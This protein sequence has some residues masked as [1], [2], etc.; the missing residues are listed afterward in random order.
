MA[1]SNSKTTGAKPLGQINL[2][3]SLQVA[4]YG[5]NLSLLDAKE[6]KG[7]LHYV[8]HIGDLTDND[9]DGIFSSRKRTGMMS[10]VH[11]E[12]DGTTLHDKYYKLKSGLPGTAITDWEELL[13][14]GSTVIIN[15]IQTVTNIA[16]RNA[17][18]GISTGDV[19]HVTDASADIAIITGGASY[20]Y[21]GST[22]TRILG[23]DGI[24]PVDVVSNTAARHV[25]NEDSALDAS[26]LNVT[27]LDINAHINDAAK[28]AEINDSAGLTNTNDIWSADKIKTELNI[29]VADVTAN[30]VDIANLISAV[31][32]K[33]DVILGYSLVDDLEVVKIH[34]RNKD[35][36]FKT[37]DYPNLNG[38]G[39]VITDIAGLRQ[40]FS[41]N[42]DIGT[43][44]NYV[45]SS[46]NKEVKYVL[47]ANNVADNGTSIIRPADYAI[48]SNEKVW[49]IIGVGIHTINDIADVDTTGI[50]VGDAL[51]WNGTSFE[52]VGGL[53]TTNINSLI[54]VDTTTSLPNAGEV[55]TWNGSNWIPS[56]IA[57]AAG[58][59]S[60]NS[61]TGVVVLN[62]DNIAQGSTNI[63]YSD[64]L[65][66]ANSNVVANTAKISYTDSVAVGLNTAKVGISSQQTNDIVS[67]NAKVGYTDA[68]VS[69][70]TDV[71]ANTSKV[72]ITPSQASDITSNNSKVSYTDAS[73]VG[74]NTAKVGITT[75]QANEITANN[76]KVGITPTQASDIT[77]NNSKS[78]ITSGQSSDITANNAKISY[79]DAA[80]VANNTA[81]TGI[82]SG[83][84]SDITTN[85]AKIS[86]T[87]SAA[88]T[89]NTSK[90]GITPT[91]AS[92]I[93]T[94][95]SKISYTDA[96]AVGLNTA[97]VS[98]NGS[99]DS[100]SDVDTS[101]SAPSTGEFL[102]WD[103]SNWVPDAIPV[104]TTL[105]DVG[106][107]TVTS[108]TSGDIIQWNGS[109]WVNIA[110]PSSNPTSVIAS[111][112]LSTFIVS[113]HTTFDLSGANLAHKLIEVTMDEAFTGN[114]TFTNGIKGTKYTIRLVTATTAYSATIA[115]AATTK[116]R[117]GTALIAPN[118]SAWTHEYHVEFDGT[119][120]WVTPEY[121]QN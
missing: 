4:A 8:K 83:Q 50:A 49:E 24:N 66:N 54:D 40:V 71:L 73:A 42:L 64:L 117:S 53:V 97:K 88:V 14:G 77:A 41:L 82:T 98:A 32:N 101:T 106:N 57:V 110:L 81:K 55:L 105:D 116:V 95:N 29:I 31:S 23:A 26:G 111:A 65:V 2:I 59:T 35:T 100:H 121:D 3:Q 107:V 58:V 46:S 10:Y 11:Y 33:V 92:E 76:S 103:G 12:N 89:A 114:L 69:A 102:K 94:N 20:I 104:I 28:H 119:N 5:T 38:T 109:A 37:S 85:N 52:V 74:L 113:T 27:A 44:I 112:V 93:V 96:T 7:G 120:Y 75:A 19:A 68:L 1:Y 22:W 60:I 56:V 39:T 84:A 13:F 6:I 99:V 48:S 45:G 79:T 16:A 86:Y 15:S 118:N 70:N 78:G 87:D 51:I 80:V 17:L 90:T 36:A 43:I 62:T 18:T 25:V 72:G 34:E 115:L 108:A 61:Q 63:Y 91:Q 30:D 67:N 21:D 9:W 47:S